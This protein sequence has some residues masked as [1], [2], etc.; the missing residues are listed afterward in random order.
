[1]KSFH[2]YEDWGASRGLALPEVCEAYSGDS[3]VGWYGAIKA[4]LSRMIDEQEKNR[5]QEYA[6]KLTAFLKTWRNNELTGSINIETVEVL[7]ATASQ[8]AVDK[9]NLRSYFENLETSLSRLVADQEQLP[10]GVDTK[11]NMGVGGGAGF[12]A[13]PMGNDFG[14][15]EEPP[16]GKPDEKPED[17]VPGA[18][19]EKPPGEEDKTLAPLR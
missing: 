4:Q 16:G 19:N 11:Q 8:L 10:T 1:M 18:A 2:S 7:K 3:I 5:N 6:D 17:N 9:W 14:P 15:E 12:S 13:P